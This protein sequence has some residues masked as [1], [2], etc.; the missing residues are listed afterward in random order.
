MKR[1]ISPEVSDFR[2]SNNKTRIITII[3]EAQFLYIRSA[4]NNFYQCECLW[5]E[6]QKQ[7]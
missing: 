6:N 7:K 3:S 4:L 1:T 5:N 2:E